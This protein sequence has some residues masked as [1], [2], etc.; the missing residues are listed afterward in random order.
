MAGLVD[1]GQC[2]A[3]DCRVCPGVWTSLLPSWAQAAA[4]SLGSVVRKCHLPILGS[5][6]GSGNSYSRCGAW[7]MNGAKLAGVAVGFAAAGHHL[8]MRHLT[9]HKSL[10]PHLCHHLCITTYLYHHCCCNLRAVILYIPRDCGVKL[11][12]LPGIFGSSSPF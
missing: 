7:D 8:L 4:S 12:V 10:T 3:L 1:V 5:C 2:T 11:E 6:L 9:D